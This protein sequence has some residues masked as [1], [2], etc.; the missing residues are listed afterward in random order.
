[1]ATK[2]RT[3]TATI[4]ASLQTLMTDKIIGHEAE[5]D[6]QLVYPF[7]PNLCCLPMDAGDQGTGKFYDP[8][9]ATGVLQYPGNLP[10]DRTNLKFLLS[11]WL[12]MLSKREQMTFA[13]AQRSPTT[14]YLGPTSAGD[15]PDGKQV[16]PAFRFQRAIGAEVTKD[17][18]VWVFVGEMTNAVPRTM[19]GRIFWWDLSGA[20]LPH[21]LGGTA[22]DWMNASPL[23]DIVG[24]PVPEQP[25]DEFVE[26]N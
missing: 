23:H 18:L 19:Y 9:S 10:A 12:S 13:T 5:L 16:W 21:E 7:D 20:G 3:A 24:V 15:W 25:T 11:A 26:L 14:L 22:I 8:K 6:A 2:D 4:A 17:G 1:M